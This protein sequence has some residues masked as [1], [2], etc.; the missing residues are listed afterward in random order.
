M[1][2]KELLKMPVREW[3]DTK[4]QYSRILI[5]PTGRRHSSGYMHI[6][7]I[8]VFSENKEE[9]YE[10]CAFPDD[11]S[12]LFPLQ[13]YGER[14]QFL[15]AKVRL[16]CLYPGGIFQYHGKGYFTVGESLSSVD[17]FFHDFEK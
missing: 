11:I 9:K 16:D 5:V 6:A 15:L 13:A 1:N 4:R 17:I 2:K 14:N 12:C 3:N 8:G 7:I 10:I